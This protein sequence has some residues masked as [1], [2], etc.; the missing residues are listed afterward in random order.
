VAYESR[1]LTAHILE[2]LAVVL[3]LRT[4]LHCLL[5]LLVRPRPADGQLGRHVHVAQDEVL[6]IL[7]QNKMF[8]R[9]IDEIEDFHFDVT[10]LLGTRRG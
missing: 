4:F 3:A 5:G 6:T 7:H 9:W 8:L 10:S 1:K 2:L